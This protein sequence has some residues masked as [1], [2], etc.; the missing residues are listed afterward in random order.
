LRKLLGI[1][2]VV[3][4]VLGTL[5]CVAAIGMGW[6]AAGRT[7]DRVT[8][9]T[10]HLDH[11]LSE[12]DARLERVEVRL[13]VIRGELADARGEAE[14]LAADNPELPRVRA[15]IERL[16][17]RLIPTIERAAALA[18]SLRTV[19]AGL[20][21]A[22]DVVTQLG[23]EVKQPSRARAAADAIDRAAA[24]LNV[25]QARINAIKSAGAVRITRELIE[26]AREAAAGSERLAQGLA[27][28]RRE[29]AVA[30]ERLAEWQNRVVFWVRVAAVAHTLIWLWIGLGQVSL[31]G[32]GR[33]QFARRVPN[34]TEPAP[35]RS[36]T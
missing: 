5:V 13:A 22:E 36:A 6:W 27:D 32:W 7:T 21:A 2:A 14:K 30:R 10:G 28:A 19:A 9:V 17:D 18:D 35:V 4:G 3:L 16:L 26:L 15:A 23:L 8:R 25:P 11:G 12:A 24:E 20:R 1:G 31:I 34:A 29:V 33:R